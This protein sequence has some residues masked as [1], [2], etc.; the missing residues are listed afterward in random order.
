MN[1]EH[2]AYTPGDLEVVTAHD[3]IIIDATSDAIDISGAKAICIEFTG[4]GITTR[5]AVLTATI[6]VDG[7]N[8][9]AYSMLIDNAANT[10][11]Q[12]L[13]RVASK[14]RTATGTDILW[15]TPETLAFKEMKIAIDITDSGTPAGSYTVNVAIFR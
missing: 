1:V 3:A 7:T 9:H 2:Y 14:T 5:E 10:N 15:M 11:A 4:T 6:S 13:L 8:F 12:T